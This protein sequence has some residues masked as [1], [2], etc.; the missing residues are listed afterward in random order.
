MNGLLHQVIGPA[1][2]SAVLVSGMVRVALGGEADADG[3]RTAWTSGRVTGSPDPPPPYRTAPRF[4]KLRF[5][6]PLLVRSD[7]AGHRLWVGEQ[8]GRVFSFPDEREIDAADLFVDLAARFD[9]LVPHPT[10]TRIGAFYGLAFHPQY[11]D[12]PYCWMTYTL[13]GDP[14]QRHPED[15]TRLSRFRVRFDA[16]GRPVCDVRSERVLLTWLEGGHN[17]G[18]LEFG[19]DGMLYVSTGDGEVP[20]PPDPR[21]AGQDVTNL[22]ST[23]LR[24]DVSVD[25]AAPW[26]RVPPDNPFVDL[27]QARPEIWAYGFRNPW[28]MTFAPDGDL[29]CGDVGW[30][31]YEMVYRVHR[32]GNY[33]WSIMEGPQP[34]R[35]QADRGPT[36]IRPPAIAL[37]HSDAAS[38]TGGYVYRGQ[39]LPELRAQYVFGDYETRRIWAATPDGDR[40]TRLRDLVPPTVRLVALGEDR[41][42]ELLLLDYDDGRI[43]ELVPN[44]ASS[45]D[46][47]FPRRLSETGVFRETATLQ[48][49]PGV[50]AFTIAAPMWHDG[51]MAER[52]VAVP[53]AEPV[54]VLP[55]QTRR[56]VGLL[57]EWMVFPRDSVLTRTVSLRDD[58]GRSVRL[59]TQLL[60]FDGTNWVGYS[61]AWN[62]QQSDADLV[63]AA[64]QQLSLDAYGPFADRRTWNIPARAECVRCHNH[65]AGGALAFTLP[66]LGCRTSDG[67]ANQLQVLQDRGWLT[68]AIPDASAGD[69]PP[70]FAPLCNPYDSGAEL[71]RRARSYLAVNCAHCHQNGAGGTA[72]IDLRH[73]IQRTEMNCFG[74]RPVQGHFT[75]RDPAI[76]APGDP[77]RSVL[78]YRIACAGRGRMPHIGS[79]VVDAAGVRLIRDWIRET[80]P[81]P[82][83]PSP[84]ANP[85]DALTESTAVPEIMT[86]A[87]RALRLLE[88]LDAGEISDE[89]RDA[90]LTRVRDA[91]EE[92]ATLFTRFQPVE[93]RQRPAAAPDRAAMLAASGDSTRGAD[94]FGS[95][96]LQCR[97]CHRVGGTGGQVGPEL[98]DVGRRLSRAEILDSLLTPSQLIDP[99]YRAWTAVKTDGTVVTGLLQ[100]RTER[101]VVLRTPKQDDVT[102]PRG[103]LEELIPQTVSLM[104]DRLLSGLSTDDVADLL[105]YLAD[106]RAA[107]PS[108]P[109]PVRAPR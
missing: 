91:P 49:A 86:D 45:A 84:A 7:P 59:E 52:Y 18:C 93:F 70:Q 23:I 85:L 43:F 11:P 103:E 37:P 82:E 104:P 60:H 75:L 46:S 64:G 100:A 16:A 27:P 88:L 4:P 51:A 12:V 72:T 96:Q 17:G 99:R 66:Q 80:D 55:R 101:S 1:L 30:E 87:S 34:V 79:S 14:Q 65:W 2:I 105:Q 3:Q 29:W 102:V 81:P 73:T 97:N 31:L 26:Y 36:P 92:I 19:P 6:R 8:A 21:D 41:D 10:A 69:L 13:V 25:D 95:P 33:G 62:T 35:P 54:Q 38:V 53:G 77:S 109:A 83:R 61:Y 48:P 44:E 5:E 67:A 20:N 28:K 32:G 57:R 58:D 63:P 89:Q 106:L 78:L 68:G 90:L 47:P 9:D 74:V 71:E 50:A 40:L 56:S 39:R 98:D 94:L 24:I 76:I 107:P 22:L 15:G 108:D 42:G